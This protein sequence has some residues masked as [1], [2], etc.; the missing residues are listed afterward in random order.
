MINVIAKL[1]KCG[2]T[3]WAEFGWY[4]VRYS[5]IS[6]VGI[7]LLSS[8]VYESGVA[9]WLYLLSVISMASIAGLIARWKW[10]WSVEVK[11]QIVGKWNHTNSGD[12]IEFREDGTVQVYGS[13][14]TTGKWRYVYENHIKIESPDMPGRKLNIDIDGNR[15]DLEEGFQGREG[16]VRA[17]VDTEEYREA[18]RTSEEALHPI[19]HVMVLLGTQGFLTLPLLGSSNAEQEVMIFTVACGVSWI[20]GIVV[21]FFTT[22]KRN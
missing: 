4:G 21:W 13:K 2:V 10:R 11:R 15:M 1:R 12:S 3:V 6:L 22:R 20:A 8:L 19:D 16:Y 17:E 5:I 9:E 14:A 7:Y 18:L